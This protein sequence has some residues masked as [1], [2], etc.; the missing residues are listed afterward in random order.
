MDIITT[1]LLVFGLSCAICIPIGA[2]AAF[3]VWF[4]DRTD[5]KG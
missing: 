1:I 2:I 3:I 4:I 5:K